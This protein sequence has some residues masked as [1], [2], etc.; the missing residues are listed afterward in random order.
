MGL[1][2][3]DSIRVD[4]DMP[5]CLVSWL[6][7]LP[8]VCGSL[9]L[10]IPLIDNWNEYPYHWF[11]FVFFFIAAALSLVSLKWGCSAFRPV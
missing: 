5:L 8:N 9:E 11:C 1:Y 3:N 2:I 4:S 10:M 7:S 6:E